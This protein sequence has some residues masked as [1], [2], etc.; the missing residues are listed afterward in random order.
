MPRFIRR[1]VE[2]VA[3][4]ESYG[5]FFFRT[6]AFQCL[7]R[8]NQLVGQALLVCRVIL[9]AVSAAAVRSKYM[10]AELEIAAEKN[11]PIVI[12]RIDQTDPSAVSR[13]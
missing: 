5:A 12:C 9:V 3:V 4:A 11:M 1:Y 2:G 8:T 10:K 13:A 6:N 7:K